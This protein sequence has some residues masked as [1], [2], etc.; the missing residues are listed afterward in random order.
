MTFNKDI[1]GSILA[2]F[3]ISFGGLL[4]HLEIHPPFPLPGVEGPHSMFN[5]YAFIPALF[6]TLVIPFLFNSRKTVRWAY[7]FNWLT[8]IVGTVTMTYF[9][10]IN[11]PEK[12][13][14]YSILLQTTLADILILF[15]KIPLGQQILNYYNEQDKQVSS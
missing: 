11:P 10:I 5:L 1:S 3:F 14:I 12:I 8:V 6:N 2:I 7:L 13:N 9:S 4:L 15:A